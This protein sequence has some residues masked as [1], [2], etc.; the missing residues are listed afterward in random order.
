MPWNDSI[1][2]GPQN[3]TFA[4]S[5]RERS[6]DTVTVEIPIPIWQKLM[7]YVDLCEEEINGLGFVRVLAPDLIVVDDIFILKQEVSFA[8][9]AI[10]EAAYH[11][12]ITDLVAENERRAQIGQPELLARLQWHS[13]VNMSTFTSSTDNDTIEN[14]T[15]DWRISLIINKRGQ[16]HIQLDV[17]RPFRISKI[18]A[19]LRISYPAASAELITAC[20]ANIRKS[21]KRRIFAYAVQDN[22]R[23]Y[24]KPTDLTSEKPVSF[25]G[26]KK[27]LEPDPIE[28][29]T[30]VAKDI[31]ERGCVIS[32]RDLGWHDRQS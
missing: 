32:A 2:H 22:A 7:T 1:T 23:N 28:K 4:P 15:S 20:K 3:T 12:F 27:P 21:V 11:K 6:R 8:S 5:T 10:D 25:L 19:E 30:K 13:H 31:S 29:D 16:H 9:A 26:K 18:K 24:D 17:Y 14:C